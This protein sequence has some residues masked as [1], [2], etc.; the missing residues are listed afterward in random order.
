ME[1]AEP[2]PSPSSGAPTSLVEAP[3]TPHVD[4][5]LEAFL[6]QTAPG[7][8]LIRT[9]M[10]GSVFTSGSDMCLLICGD[11]PY[12]YAKELGVGIDDITIAFAVSDT[13][14]IAMIAYRARG[15]E[16]DRLIPAR[17]AI[18]GYTGHGGLYDLPVTVA[19]RPATYLDGG[20]GE[21]GEYLMTRH[22]VLFIVLG[23]APTKGECRP[24]SC[25]SPPPGPWTPPAYVTEALAAVP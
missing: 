14:G 18:G 9:S 12:R 20:M 11:E 19:G 4:P 10:P 17:I 7:A 13:L 2:L 16:T 21:T 5:A 22:D 3:G 25:A 23:E 6:P 8:F 1:S 15:A 24:G